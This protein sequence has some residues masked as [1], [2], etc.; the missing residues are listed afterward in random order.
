MQRRRREITSPIG[1]TRFT[2]AVCAI[3]LVMAC[4]AEPVEPAVAI[5][6]VAPDAG[7]APWPDS[8]A[9]DSSVPDASL[10]EQPPDASPP[11]ASGLHFVDVGDYLQ[12]PEEIDAWYE[13]L[14]SLR[15]DFD[16]VCG[17]T[18]CEG[19]F[20][21]YQSLRFRCSVES[22]TGVMGSCAWV[23]AAS[24]EEVVAETGAIRSEGKIF[25]CEMPLQPDTS[26]GAFFEAMSRPDSGPIRAP[27]PGTELT[28]FDG[29]AEC[30]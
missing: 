15:R 10:P 27:L 25:R 6:E 23:L 1:I 7:P 22:S 14:A 9:P 2:L 21:N 3:A 12:V 29:L 18:F 8:S 24:N 11:D 20:S 13:L 4:Q 17:D 26:L 19:D 30:L 16:D 5:A 28:L